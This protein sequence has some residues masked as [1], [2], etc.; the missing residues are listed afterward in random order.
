MG[1]DSQTAVKVAGGFG[2]GMYL[3]SLC[4]AITGGIMAIGLKYGGVGVQPSV[5]T[6]NIVRTFTDRFIAKHRSINCTDLIGGVDLSK[7]DMSNP[8]NLSE[9]YKAAIQ[10]KVY[11]SC[12]MYVKDAA[13]IVNELLNEAAKSES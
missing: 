7:I 9:F 8:E 2:G 13:T 10:K 4:G 5:Q 1:M 3:G 11:A 12:P 6:A